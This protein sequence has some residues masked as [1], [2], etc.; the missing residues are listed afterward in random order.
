MRKRLAARGGAR[1]RAG[2]K[3]RRPARPGAGRVPGQIRRP[4]RDEVLA[5]LDASKAVLADAGDAASRS[6]GAAARFVVELVQA[7]ETGGARSEAL[8]ARQHVGRRGRRRRHDAGSSGSG[9]APRAAPPRRPRRLQPKKPKGGTTSS[10]ERP[11][12]PHP[13]P[14]GPADHA[15][16]SLGASTGLVPRPAAAWRTAA[17]AS[18]RQGQSP[19]AGGRPRTS[20]CGPWRTRPR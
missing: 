10:P 3:A 19:W 9:S 1:R 8:P 17:A 12:P 18:P 14:Q 13:I 11:G 2:E 6:A 16:E 15:V 4:K 5:E 20:R 7:V